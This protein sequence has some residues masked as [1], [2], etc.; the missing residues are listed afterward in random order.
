MSL[1][2]DEYATHRLLISQIVPHCMSK[3]GLSH[4]RRK[5]RKV[6]VHDDLVFHFLFVDPFTEQVFFA[7]CLFV[8][9]FINLLMIRGHSMLH[10][11]G[12]R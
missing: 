3:L 10:T 6:L 9:L 5:Q 7:P 1:L 11:L 4:L 8:F 2:T 12:I